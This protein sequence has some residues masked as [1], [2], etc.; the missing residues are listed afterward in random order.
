MLPR[1]T[2]SLAPV[3]LGTLPGRFNKRR[4]PKIMKPKASLASL[5]IPNSSLVKTLRENNSRS[6][7][8]KCLFLLPPPETII[9]EVGGKKRFCWSIIV[10]AVNS[11]KV[12]IMSRFLR[13]QAP[14]RNLSPL[15][16][17]FRCKL[18]FRAFGRRKR[19]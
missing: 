14:N 11:V 13:P 17:I 2:L 12:A 8:I 10:C 4:C 19:K 15:A 5:L 9:L 7:F 16:D 6:R 18:L 3:A 1:H